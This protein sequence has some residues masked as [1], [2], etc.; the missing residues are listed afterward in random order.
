MEI[1][2][3][4]DPSI[5]V[6]LSFKKA[7]LATFFIVWSINLSNKWIKHNLAQITTETPFLIVLKGHLSLD[8][9]AGACIETNLIKLIR[10]T[11]LDRNSFLIPEEEPNHFSF[12]LFSFRLLFMWIIGRLLSQNGLFHAQLL[13]E[14]FTIVVIFTQKKF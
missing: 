3:V 1:Q 6:N 7:F 14:R 9:Q 2:D 11:V 4:V 5:F 10:I 12:L 8:H 13:L